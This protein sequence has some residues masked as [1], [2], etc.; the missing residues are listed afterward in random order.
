MCSVIPTTFCDYQMRP[1]L[2]RPPHIYIYVYIHVYIY[3]YICVYIYIHTHTH[4]YK[5][6]VL[7]S[8]QMGY[9]FFCNT[10]ILYFFSLSL[11]TWLI[12]V[13]LAFS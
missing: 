5:F 7:E 4:K 12:I 11:S 13:P 6:F 2:F 10:A 9:S 8:R 1:L 3:M